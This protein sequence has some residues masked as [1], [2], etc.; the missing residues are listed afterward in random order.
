MASITF[1]A[2][3]EL[4]ERSHTGQVDQARRPYIGHPLGV[5]E[6]IRQETERCAVR[7]DDPGWTLRPEEALTRIA[8]VLHDILEDQQ[9][10]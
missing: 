2:A 5:A 6:A 4:A 10:S 9:R 7:I 3:V 1:E 8:A